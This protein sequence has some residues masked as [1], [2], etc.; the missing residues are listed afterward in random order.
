[1]TVIIEP[2]VLLESSKSKLAMCHECTFIPVWRMWRQLDTK[3]LYGYACSTHVD[4]VVYLT[5]KGKLKVPQKPK[6][7]VKDEES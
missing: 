7:V 2:Y 5:L 6:P 4:T 1:M 3:P